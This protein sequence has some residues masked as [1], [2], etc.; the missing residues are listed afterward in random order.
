VEGQPAIAMKNSGA[1]LAQ[2][3]EK[4]KKTAAAVNDGPPE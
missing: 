2:K 4:K 3:P 1:Y